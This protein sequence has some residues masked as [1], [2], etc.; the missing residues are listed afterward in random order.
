MKKKIYIAI[1]ILLSIGGLSSCKE[2]NELP[3]LDRGYASEVVLPEPEDLTRE[4]RVYLE[5]LEEEYNNSLN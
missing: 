2:A 5:G 1:V 3:P 4:D